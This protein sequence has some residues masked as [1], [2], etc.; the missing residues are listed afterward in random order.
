VVRMYYQLMYLKLHLLLARVSLKFE[1]FPAYD[2]TV[3]YLFILEK[4][5]SCN[6]F[7]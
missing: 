3:K 4:R 1:M 7:L 6:D 2:G 5:E